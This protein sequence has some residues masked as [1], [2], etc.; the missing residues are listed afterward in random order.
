MITVQSG[1]PASLN[2][3]TPWP[4]NA[5]IA[6]PIGSPSTSVAFV[7]I[8][9]LTRSP[10]GS[11][12]VGRTGVKCG[13]GLAFSTGASFTGLIAATA[14]SDAELNGPVPPDAA[15]VSARN[16]AVPRVRS[17]ALYVT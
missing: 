9:R 4:A 6:M 5:V 15:V 10:G 13:V 14:V 16:P 11:V 17:Q 7:P 2:C 1:D 8:R 3:Q 12:S